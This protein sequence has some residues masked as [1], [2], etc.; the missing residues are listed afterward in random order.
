MSDQYFPILVNNHNLNC[1]IT[2]QEA[3][4][5][6]YVFIVSLCLARKYLLMSRYFPVVVDRSRKST[7]VLTKVQR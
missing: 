1:V 3:Q 4:H 2:D 7:G 6:F 5:F